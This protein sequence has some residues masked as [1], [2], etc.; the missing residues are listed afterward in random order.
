MSLTLDQVEEARSRALAYLMKAGIILTP[1]E[2]ESIAILDFGLN[3]PERIGAQVVTYISN[4]RYCAK[5]LVLFP[6][7]I[8]PEHW[9]PS[10]VEGHP[11]KLETYRCRWGLVYLYV[12]GEVT[13][14]PYGKPPEDRQAFTAWHQVVLRVGQQYTVGPN[15]RHWMQAGG[16]GAVISEFSSPCRDEQDLFTDPRVNR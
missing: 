10:P 16:Q 5:E 14:N 3:D 7:Q 8:L 13:P 9:H 12:E 15:T 2:Q 6:H 4:E 11:G 1:Q